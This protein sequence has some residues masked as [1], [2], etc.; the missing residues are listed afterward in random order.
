MRH[1]HDRTQTAAGRLTVG[2]RDG[3]MALTS[4]DGGPTMIE[5]ELPCES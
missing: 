3:T 4:P 1:A 2:A 5:V